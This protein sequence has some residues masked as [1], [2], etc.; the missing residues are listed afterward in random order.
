MSGYDKT[1]PVGMLGMSYSFAGLCEPPV[2]RSWL[3][4][5]KISISAY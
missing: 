2:R 3:R 4:T 5:R 1:H